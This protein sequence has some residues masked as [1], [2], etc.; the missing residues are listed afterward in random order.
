MDGLKQT[1]NCKHTLA[2]GMP[3]ARTTTPLWQPHMLPIS[4]IWLS[5]GRETCLCGAVFGFEGIRGEARLNQLIH[6]EINTALTPQEDN[7]VAVCHS[8]LLHSM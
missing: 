7:I 3:A 2:P 8:G 1:T 6:D 5:G 4:L